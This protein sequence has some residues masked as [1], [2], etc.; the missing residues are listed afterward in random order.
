MFRSERGTLWSSEYEG[1]VVDLLNDQVQSGVE[2]L[3]VHLDL[4]RIL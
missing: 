4:W 3:I 2:F 1:S